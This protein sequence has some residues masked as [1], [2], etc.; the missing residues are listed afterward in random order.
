MYTGWESGGRNH[1]GVV[2]NRDSLDDAI[3]ID[4]GGTGTTAG[5]EWDGLRP[6]PYQVLEVT[7]QAFSYNGDSTCQDGYTSGIVC[8]LTVVNVDENG[9][10]HR[11][12]EARQ[13]NGNTAGRPGEARD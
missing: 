6:G 1:I 4:T 11:G 2:L 8:G 7:G 13:V 3:A 5:R 9:V 10:S 12:V